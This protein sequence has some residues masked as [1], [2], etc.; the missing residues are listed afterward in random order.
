MMR[1]FDYPHHFGHHTEES[2]MKQ[3]A[4]KAI[5]A[6]LPGIIIAL[7]PAPH[8]LDVHA[9]YYFAIFTAVIFGLILEPIPA[10]AIGFAGI[11]LVA[12]LG[13]AGPKPADSIR[14][15]LSGFSNTTVWLIFGAFMFALGYEKTGLGRRIALNMV[16]ALGKKTLGLGYAIT[17]SDLILAPFTPSNTARSAGTIFPII[18]NLPGLYGSA[19]GET[20]RRIGSYIMWTALAATCVTSS[21]FITSMAPNLLAVELVNKTVQVNVTWMEWAIGF[22]PVGVIL[23]LVVPFLVYKIY[24]PDIRESPEVS[25]WASQEIEKMGRIT[26]KELIMAI[27]AIL[28]LSLWIFGSSL[29]DAAAVAGITISLMVLTGV[30]TW[31]DVLG[32]KP[33]WNV[34]V[35]FATMVAMADGLN[36]V[37]FVAW[38]TK[39][40]SALLTGM[41]PIAVMVILVAIFF[42]VHYM[43][44]SITAHTTA[45][46]VVILAAGAAVPGIPVKTFALLLCYSLGIMGIIT[47]Y[48]TGP[49]PA[50]YGSG[51][52][53]RKAFWT[54]G[55]ILGIIFLVALLSVG[56]PYLLMIG[57]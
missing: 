27:L 51:Y 19:P 21:M 41:S 17:F 18:R 57:Y 5:L 30:V 31:D 49:S 1:F 20:A 52:I 50:Y 48:G 13:L 38:F 10:A 14:W 43:F 35:W 46:L 3:T 39:S 42:F 22:L 45:V 54:L 7:L 29:L 56:I 4:W 53:S 23:I 32:N 34:L 2:G 26:R 6:L 12:L 16:R 33:A 44:A 40:A 24:P 47:P 25:H 55:F 8:G 9:W 11:F 28:A 15:A 37:G 36:K